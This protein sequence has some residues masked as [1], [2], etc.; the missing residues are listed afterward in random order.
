MNDGETCLRRQEVGREAESTG[1]T[2]LA[3]NNRK[4]E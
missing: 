2:A 4:Y 3:L 1:L